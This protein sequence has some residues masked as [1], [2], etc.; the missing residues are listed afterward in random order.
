M[1]WCACWCMRVR[2]PFPAWLEIHQHC[3]WHIP[4]TGCLVEI[5]VNA[6][7]SLAVCYPLTRKLPQHRTC[8]V[9]IHSRS[10]WLLRP[11]IAELQAAN[12]SRRDKFLAPSA[13][14]ETHKVNALHKVPCFL[15]LF[16]FPFCSSAQV[17]NSMPMWDPPLGTPQF[18][19]LISFIQSVLLY[20][21]TEENQKTYYI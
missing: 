11:L 16:F 21:K 10:F 17:I 2:D 1:Q 18:D 6:L 15:D 19:D 3:A 8:F 20:C 4:S 13:S 5:D 14:C 7:L 9:R 12:Q